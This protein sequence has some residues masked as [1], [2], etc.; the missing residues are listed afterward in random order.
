MQR[1][2]DTLDL[3]VIQDQEV[4]GFEWLINHQS[5]VEKFTGESEKGSGNVP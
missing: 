5:K 2:S 3:P 4:L 1:C